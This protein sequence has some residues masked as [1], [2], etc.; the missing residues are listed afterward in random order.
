M[1]LPRRG[2][3]AELGSFCCGR[4]R[5]T[6]WPSRA[7]A[8]LVKSPADAAF[9]VRSS[10]FASPRRTRRP[11]MRRTFRA[12]QDP[13]PKLSLQKPLE[14]VLSREGLAHFV[15]QGESHLNYLVQ[16]YVDHYQ[17]QRPHQGLDNKLLA[18]ST[19]PDQDIPLLQAP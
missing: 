17:V 3:R 7:K 13:R 9:K 5:R 14:T 1:A 11:L 2:K 4:Q 8:R 16:V 18:P 19:P 10:G 6:D 12:P 15:V